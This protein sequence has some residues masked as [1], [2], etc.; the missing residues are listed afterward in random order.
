M[1]GPRK[2]MDVFAVEMLGLLLLPPLAMGAF[3]AVL[4]EPSDFLPGFGIGLVV[5]VGAAK[6]RNEIRGV[7]EDPDS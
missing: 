4:G 2:S 1:N 5:G 6:L 7:R 3:L